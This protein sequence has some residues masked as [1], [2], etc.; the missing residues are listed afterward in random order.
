M[1][2]KISESVYDIL[3]AINFLK[4]QG[5]KKFY[6]MG[7]SLGCT[8]IVY[9]YSQMIKTNNNVLKDIKK[10]LLLSPVDIAGFFE[11]ENKNLARKSLK[12]AIKLMKKNKKEEL[13]ESGMDY[14]ISAETFIESVDPQTS[15]ISYGENSNYLAFNQIQVPL[16]IRFGT[17]SEM[18][19][20]SP[21]KI[22]SLLKEKI[23]NKF[24]DVNFIKGANHSYEDKEK[25]LA[26]QIYNFIVK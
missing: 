11:N 18:I 5:F 2:E 20:Q 7:H 12:K 25:I 1:Y 21:E 4:K 14:N 23:E 16:F 8:K 13:V 3:G 19:V 15:L 10:V 9:F 24:L 26:K 22:V 17:E 6:L